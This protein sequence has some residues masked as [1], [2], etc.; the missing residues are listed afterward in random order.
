MIRK[1]DDR[2]EEGKHKAVLEKCKIDLERNKLLTDFGKETLD[3][4]YLLAGENYQDMFARVSC[5][6]ADDQDHAQRLYDYM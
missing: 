6:F 5:A 2:F 3:D 4:R 1:D